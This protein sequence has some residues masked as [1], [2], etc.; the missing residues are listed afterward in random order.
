MV[1]DGRFDVRPLLAVVG[2]VLALTAGCSTGNDPGPGPATTQSA[3]PSA[4][5]TSTPSPAA[6]AGEQ[7]LTAYRGMWADFVAAGTTSDWQSPNLGHHATGVALT[8]LS[9]GL[10]ADRVNGLV[11][12]GE[13]SLS[14]A[15]SS[16]EP[17]SDPTR[18]VVTD[19]G[20]STRWLKHRVAD[21]SIVNAG[22]GGR[23]LIN[24]VVE[25]QSDGSWKV[26]D[27]GVQGVGSC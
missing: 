2:L 6:V 27:Y 15:V 23:R 25:R 19:C 26:S 13:P 10:Y 22:S 3:V 9:R 21:G 24:A 11:T 17:A 20:D 1:G 14:P 5:P 16:A 12:R 7:A 18:V 8:N 4:A